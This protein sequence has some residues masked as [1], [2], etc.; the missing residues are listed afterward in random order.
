[1]GPLCG[2]FDQRA[3]ELLVHHADTLG[4]DAISVGG[5][6]SW[7]MECLAEGDLKPEEIGIDG[8]P[9]FTAEN[10]RVVEDSL[11]NGQIGMQMLNQIITDNGKINLNEGARKFARHLAWEKG[12][13]VLDK[14]VY[15]GFARH[16]WIVPNQYW[17]PGVLSPMAIMGKYYMNY[18]K[19]FIEPR[20]LGREDAK[21]MI[22]ELMMDNMGICRFHR[23]WAEDIMPEIIEQLFGLKE[24]FLASLKLTASRINS[25]NASTFWESERNIDFIHSF[26]LKK[27]N[28]DGVDDPSLRDW[29]KRFSDDKYKAALDFW[30]DMHKGI[31]ESL[32]E[33]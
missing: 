33:F 1:M 11:H 14:F 28:E 17:S 8:I 15:V 30:Y 4:F 5:I 2:V 23:A 19:D 13:N 9:V 3:A 12:K 20:E 6:I 22:M 7:L 29:L 32:R 16:G 10:F 24:E 18:G 21:R 27:Q 25:R 31:H 26:L